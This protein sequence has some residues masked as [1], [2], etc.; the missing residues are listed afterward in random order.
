MFRTNALGAYFLI[1]AV[2]P[3]MKKQGGGRIINIVSIAGVFGLKGET[4]YNMSKFALAGL[5]KNKRKELIH[6]NIIVVNL[7]PGGID[8]PFWNNRSVKIDTKT[9]LRPEAVAEYALL[10]A[11]S[12]SVPEEIIINPT[13]SYKKRFG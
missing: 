2:S 6:D 4:G 3:I 9:M 8:T 12:E 1:N 7:C 11:R 13:E 5:G 10:A